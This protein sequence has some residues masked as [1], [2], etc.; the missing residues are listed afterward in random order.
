MEKNVG[1]LHQQF[2]A[3]FPAIDNLLQ[4]TREISILQKATQCT[5]TE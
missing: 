2:E 1:K 3:Y 4:D 5:M